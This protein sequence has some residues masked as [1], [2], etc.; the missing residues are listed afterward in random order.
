M[1]SITTTLWIHRAEASS[2]IVHCSSNG[3]AYDIA[4]KILESKEDAVVFNWDLLTFPDPIYNGSCFHAG[5]TDDLQLSIH[6]GSYV[7]HSFWNARGTVLVTSAEAIGLGTTGE[8]HGFE[9][10]ESSTLWERETRS[11]TDLDQE[12][13]D[14]FRLYYHEVKQILTKILNHAGVFGESTT[15]QLLS[16]KDVEYLKAEAFAAQYLYSTMNKQEQEKAD[17]DTLNIIDSLGIANA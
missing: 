7:P 17:K 6:P 15:R 9:P 5:N 2:I 12:L 4:C 11:H 1:P 14:Y 16:T 10:Y 8:P 3:E 13:D